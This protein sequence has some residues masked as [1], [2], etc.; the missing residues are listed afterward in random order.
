MKKERNDFYDTGMEEIHD[1]C[2]MLEK[3]GHSPAE[4]RFHELTAQLLLFICAQ[5]LFFRRGFLA[6][7]GVIFGFLLSRALDVLLVL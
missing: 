6:L 7:S 2:N 1:I 3:E 4:C 5:L